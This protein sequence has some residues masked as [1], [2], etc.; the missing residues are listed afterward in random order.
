MGPVVFT[1]PMGINLG[2]TIGNP[3]LIRK[4]QNVWHMIVDAIK[5]NST[6]HMCKKPMVQMASGISYLFVNPAI[7]GTT[8]LLFPLT[9]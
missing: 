4:R 9:C 8:F 2:L 1:I 6:V 7:I 5:L 3:I